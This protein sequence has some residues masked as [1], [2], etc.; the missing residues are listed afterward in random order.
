MNTTKPI[1]SFNLM[2][3]YLLQAAS[4]FCLKIFKQ[5]EV[6]TAVLDQLLRLVVRNFLLEFQ[7]VGRIVSGGCDDS[8]VRKW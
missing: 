7:N 2:Q 1:R 6:L 4:L 3:R 5:R 8:M